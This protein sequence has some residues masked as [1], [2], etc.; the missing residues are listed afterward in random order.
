VIRYRTTKQNQLILDA[1]QKHCDHPTADQIYLE[2]RAS[3]DQISRG[4][5]YRNLDKLADLGSL[6]R[7]KVPGADR[8]DCRLDVHYHMICRKCGAV[9]DAPLAYHHELD[10]Q[11][12]EQTG[13]LVERHRTV[14][15]GICPACAADGTQK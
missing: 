11:V 6:L 1:V 14:F 5:V 12:L 15:E 4:T 13:F 8:Y 7:V 3:N 2:V 10:Q 9:V